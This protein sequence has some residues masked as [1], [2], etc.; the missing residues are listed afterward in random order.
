MEESQLNVQLR[1]HVQHVLAVTG[2]FFNILGSLSGIAGDKNLLGCYTV[3]RGKRLLKC[4]GLHYL[5]LEG[6]A[7]SV[8]LGV[9]DSF[10]YRY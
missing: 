5:H 10:L 7:V 4:E 6:Q 2:H 3:P 1:S 9:F 8:H